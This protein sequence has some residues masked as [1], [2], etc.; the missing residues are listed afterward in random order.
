M[1]E[2]ISLIVP[3]YNVAPYL[4]KCLASIQNQTYRN[5]EI[6]CVDD[7]SVDGSGK[8]L[9]RIAE[10]DERIRVFHQENRGTGAARNLALRHASGEFIGFVDPDDW[11]EADMYELLHDTAVRTKADVVTCG[12]Y[13]DEEGKGSR[14]AENKKKV[15]EGLLPAGEF[16]EYI[17]CRDEYKGVS[18][19]LWTRLF[20][21]EVVF[22]DGRGN[23]LWFDETLLPGQDVYF[24]AGICVRA[25]S[26]V[27]LPEHLYHYVQQPMSVMHQPEKRLKNM[28][29]CRAYQMAIELFEKEGVAART[30]DLLKRFYVYHAAVLLDTAFQVGDTE[31]I[32]KLKG[33]IRKYLL[34]YMKTNLHCPSRIVWIL[35]MLAK[36][37]AI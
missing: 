34:S 29:S 28:S 21:S 18:G 11:I 15:R 31:K 10:G 27:Y 7:G 16:L 13:I 12:Y 25:K 20:R 35:R 19:Y 4:E 24:I 1:K 32:H 37:E 36:K 9:D 17:Y 6:L 26:M 30:I 33:M 2:K 3:V 22:G 5:L 14:Q 23:M 8:L